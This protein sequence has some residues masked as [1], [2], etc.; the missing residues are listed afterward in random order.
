M[1]PALC[2]LVPP[3]NLW[4]NERL[5]PGLWG[6]DQRPQFPPQAPTPFPLLCVPGGGVGIVEVHSGRRW[7]KM[8]LSHELTF[9]TGANVRMQLKSILNR[10]APQ[11][12]FVYEKASF[13][14]TD[15]PTLEIT[16]RPRRG[17]RAVCSGCGQQRPGYDRL[18]PR[19]FEF[20]PLWG[21]AVFFNYAMRRVNCPQCGVRVERAVTWGLAHRDLRQGS[22]ITSPFQ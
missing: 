12:G 3:Q 6:R 7:W 2:L 1:Q 15:K 21:F 11:P 8:G 19:R 18:A 16:I 5:F 20:V 9:P 10:G 22:K 17:T 4:V 13:A 14:A